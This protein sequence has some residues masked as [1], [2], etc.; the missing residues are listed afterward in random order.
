MKLNFYICL[1]V[2]SHNKPNNKYTIMI[3]FSTS[4]KNGSFN[5]A[6]P[7]SLSEIPNEYLYDVTKD[8]VI[9][10]DYSLICIC[11]CEALSSVLFAN[12][13][14]KGKITTGVVPIFV[15]HGDTTNTY[16]RKINCGDKLVIAPS[17]IAMGHHVV[18][19]NNKITID[20]ILRCT[21]GDNKIYQEALKFNKPCYF[22][23]FKIVPNCNIH[24][25]YKANTTTTKDVNPFVNKI[26]E[27]K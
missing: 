27:G 3:K 23:E 16:I 11:Y 9:A 13:T 2:N 18:A 6:L 22:L 12:N 4:G 20:N 1:C 25:S 26:E 10:D 15:K 24:A 19:P 8:I 7:T 17:D 14:K 21:D 5:V